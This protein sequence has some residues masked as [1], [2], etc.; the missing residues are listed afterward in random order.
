LLLGFA[1][2]GTRGRGGT[3]AIEEEGE[4]ETETEVA[5]AAGKVELLRFG[6]DVAVVAGA[7]VGVLIGIVGRDGGGAEADGIEAVI[8]EDLEDVLGPVGILPPRETCFEARQ[9]AG[10]SCQSWA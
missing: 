10:R 2:P 6:L 3:A 4:L 5:R 1:G 8:L 7:N 9:N